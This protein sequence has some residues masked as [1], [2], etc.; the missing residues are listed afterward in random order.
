MVHISS[1]EVKTADMFQL[2]AQITN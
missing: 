2:L 1:T